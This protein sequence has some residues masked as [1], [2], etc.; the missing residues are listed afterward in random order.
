ME[1]NVSIKDLINTLPLEQSTKDIQDK[2]INENDPDE[3]KKL[4]NQFNLNL[5][6][7]NILRV[8]KL[9]ELKDLITA[10]MGERIKNRPGEFS[11]RDLIDYLSSLENSIEKANKTIKGVDEMPAIQ[12]NQV[13][14]TNN[15]VDGLSK[16]SREN[17]I[18][19]VQALMTKANEL[20]LESEN[21][22]E[23]EIVK[24]NKDDNIQG[25]DE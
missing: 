10:Q 11:N 24:E 13:N 6:K 18:K 21:T 5:A 3:I 14:V 2:I 1:D 25:T 9:D 7:K 23:G 22:V 16:E 17:I 8:D 12:F 15:G 20:D 19:A 4:I